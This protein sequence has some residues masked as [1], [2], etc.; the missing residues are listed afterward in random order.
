MVLAI[1]LDYN[2]KTSFLL[3]LDAKTV[4]EIGRAW[5]PHHNPAA[6][7][8]YFYPSSCAGFPPLG[9]VISIRV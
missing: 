6:L 1:M 5:L 8:G 2:N 7:H 9:I 3:V 4:T